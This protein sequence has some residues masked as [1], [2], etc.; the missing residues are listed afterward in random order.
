MYVDPPRRAPYRQLFEGLEMRNPY[1]GEPFTTSD[2]DIATALL[3]VSIP[4]LM[5]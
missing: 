1:A 5:L 2:E 3:D 4:T